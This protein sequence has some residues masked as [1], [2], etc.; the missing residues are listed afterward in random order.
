MAE[1]DYKCIPVPRSLFTGKVGKDPHSVAVATY[2]EIIKNSA[3]GGW[4]LDRVDT[5]SSFQ[6]PGCFAALLGKK[7]ETV[8]YKLLIFKKTI[9]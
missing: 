8:D 3:K 4:E 6:Q 1:F 5:V 2:E 9:G 7:E